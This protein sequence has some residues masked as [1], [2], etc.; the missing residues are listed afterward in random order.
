MT[1]EFEYERKIYKLEKE[2][3]A[4]RE[5]TKEMINVL[6]VLLAEIFS[7]C[8]EE[9]LAA[10]SMEEGVVKAIAHLQE[11]G[12]PPSEKSAVDKLMGMRRPK[13]MSLNLSKEIDNML[14][15]ATGEETNFGKF[16][17]LRE[18]LLAAIEKDVAE[19][20]V[21]KVLLDGAAEALNQANSEEKLIA[22]LSRFRN[23]KNKF[24]A[25]LF[26]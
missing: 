10:E 7:D 4:L 14:N 21:P 23:R 11:R 25:S 9:L 15:F 12:S 5:K 6:G 16:K 17:F 20:L 8:P 22:V 13:N 24:F 26:S 1:T 2:N 19:G 18:R 3:A